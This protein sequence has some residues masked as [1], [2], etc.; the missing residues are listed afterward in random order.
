M[1]YLMIFLGSLC[2]V[3]FIVG[4]AKSVLAAIFTPDFEW[5]GRWMAYIGSVLFLF[6]AIIFFYKAFV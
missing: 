4:A 3:L 6:G 2:S 5:Y 1:M